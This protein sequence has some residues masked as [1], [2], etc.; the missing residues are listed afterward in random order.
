MLRY[1]VCRKFKTGEKVRVRK[2]LTPISVAYPQ[3]GLMG[4][5][6]EI[7]VTKTFPYRVEVEGFNSRMNWFWDDHLEKAVS[8]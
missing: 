4:I 5:V 2:D 3:R 8:E 7:D 6:A 1:D